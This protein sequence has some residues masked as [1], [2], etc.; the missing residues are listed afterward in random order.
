[1]VNGDYI[2]GQVVGGVRPLTAFREEHDLKHVHVHTVHVHLYMYKYVSLASH[3]L[4]HP[5]Y[6]VWS[7]VGISFVLSC[8]NIAVQSDCS[9]HVFWLFVI[10]VK[11]EVATGKESFINM[12]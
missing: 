8:R 6:R 11:M 4:L 1:M 9:S 12:S 3:T 7:N 10:L 5:V 2:L